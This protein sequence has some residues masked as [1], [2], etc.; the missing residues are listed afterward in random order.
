MAEMAEIENRKVENRAIEEAATEGVVS[1]LVALTALD[2]AVAERADLE[3]ALASAGRVQ[4]WLDAFVLRVARRLEEVASFPEKVI[5]D[6]ERS[7]LRAGERVVQRS[8]TA[9]QAPVFEAALAAGAVAKGHLDALGQ[10]LRRLGPDQQVQLLADADRLVATAAKATVEDFTRTLR[11]EVARLAADTEVDRLAR[12]RRAARVRTWVDTTDG[13]WCLHGRFDPDTGRRLHDRI[14]ACAGRAVRRGHARHLPA[15]SRREA[16][17][18]PSPGRGGAHRAHRARRLRP[19]RDD[20]GRRRHVAGRAGGRLGASG[21]T[22]VACAGGSVRGDRPQRRRGPQ[23][24]RVVRARPTRPRTVDP[25]GQQG[26]AAGAA[27]AV[28]HVRH[29]GCGVR[30]RYTQPHHITWWEQGGATD[31]ANLLPLCDRHHHCVHDKDKGWRLRLG[32]GRDLVVVLP[33]GQVMTTGPPQ[34]QAA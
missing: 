34:R 31:F 23:R 1:A 10:A 3:A 17:S 16:G 14:D 5:A 32:A 21:R 33:D 24:C 9:E 25:S 26:P 27:G 29:P 13:M 11:R 6:A 7:E 19:D 2:V 12:Q 15:R 28:P 18:P 20:G 30:F 22:S 8:R 4:G